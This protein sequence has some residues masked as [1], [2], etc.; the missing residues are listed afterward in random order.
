MFSFLD[1][2]SGDGCRVITSLLKS[3]GHQVKSV[4]L[5]FFGA[6][7]DLQWGN[8]LGQAIDEADLFM[9][10]LLSCYEQRAAVVTKFLKTRYPTRP[11]VWGGVHATA[12]PESCLKY[13]DFVIR[14]ECED[15]TVEFCRRLENGEDIYAT[16]NLAYLDEAGNMVQNPLSQ[17][18]FELDEMPFPDYDLE[19]HFV[20]DGEEIVPANLE[21]YEKYHTTY[22]H[23]QPAYFII[24]TRGCPFVCS[25]CHQSELVNTY[26][27]REFKSRT[28]RYKSIQRT[29]EEIKFQTERLPFLKRVGF[30]DDDF[31]CRKLDQIK[32]FAEVYPREIGLPFGVAAIPLSIKEE[33]LVP[34]LDA[35][36]TKI[37]IGIQSGSERLNKQIYKRH[38]PRKKLMEALDLLDRY[39][40]KYDF[41]VD[42]DWI[43]DCP[44]ENE[45]DVMESVKLGLE[46]PQWIHSNVFTL[47]FYPGT[48]IYNQALEEGLIVQG[49]NVYEQAFNML[50]HEGHSYLTHVFL[51][52]MRLGAPRGLVKA[53]ISRPGR[54]IGERLPNWTL[55]GIWH[56]KLYPKLVGMAEKDNQIAGGYT[57]S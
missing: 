21:V 6:Q 15:G 14:G 34:L 5:P 36:C 25:Y 55:N 8:E 56:R 3:E 20:L 51:A 38:H 54:W 9:C 2:L 48:T 43:I 29:I 12:L 57:F 10:S 31:M 22:F 17:L 35:G 7:E 37:Q 11:M 28:L 13:A 41:T 50:R 16:A 33:K 45:D 19:D 40:Q 53:L 26:P 49:D 47:T 52:H 23:D 32:E 27:T 39:H 4:F 42:A 44:W 46:M 24:T 18:P 30:S 1:E